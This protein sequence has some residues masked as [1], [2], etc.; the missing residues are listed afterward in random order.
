ML[1][2]CGYFMASYYT[3]FTLPEELGA[4]SITP[5]LTERSPAVSENRVDR[6]QHTIW[7]ASENV[8]T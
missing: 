1:L 7:A 8:N 3:F 6:L 4:H 5:L 2:L